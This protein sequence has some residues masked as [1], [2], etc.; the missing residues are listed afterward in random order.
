MQ[1]FRNAVK[2]SLQGIKRVPWHKARY[3]FATL[4][5]DEVISSA[6]AETS[7]PSLVATGAVVEPDSPAPSESRLMEIFRSLGVLWPDDVDRICADQ[8]QTQFLVDEFLPV[9]SI[10]IAAGE[11][12]IGKSPLFCQLGLCVAAGVPFLTLSTTRARVLYFDL[13]NSLRDG[14]TIRD[15]LMKLLGLSK[16]PFEFLV[17][18]EPP[19]NLSA[20]ISDVKP[21]LVIIDSLRAFKPEVSGKNAGAGQWLKDLRS[22]TR[23]HDCTFLIV[24]HLR[25]P[26]KEY[27]T[28]DL[29]DCTVANWLLEMEGARALL[30]QTDVR[31]AVAEG[32]HES[33]SLQLKWSRRVH[34]NM[35]VM[36][37]ERVHDDDGDPLG[38]RLLTGITLLNED[39]RKAFEKLPSEFSTG[40]A[41]AALGRADEATDNFLKECKRSGLTEKLGRGR[42][43]KLPQGESQ[44]SAVEKLEEV[45][46]TIHFSHI[47]LRLPPENA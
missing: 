2:R 46:K 38:Y 42:W 21:R 29:K 25:K 14:K 31:I 45:G 7:I 13:E 23:K 43:K 18:T 10:A 5:G 41:K 35:P 26:S 24:H 39:R 34:G 33:V 19:Q 37:V 1:P 3:A 28:P 12:T 17:S 40:Q 20:V 47:P 44:S 30:N 27:P 22:I 8:K 6:H 36:L 11:S 4:S 15:S 16:A 32:N 9:Q